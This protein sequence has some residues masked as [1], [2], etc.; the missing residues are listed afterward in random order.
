MLVIG[1]REREAGGAHISTLQLLVSGKLA[2]Q[3]V[4]ALGAE[5]TAVRI[6]IPRGPRGDPPETS[7]LWRPAAAS[8]SPVCV[9]Y[10]TAA[11]NGE[12]PAAALLCT[13][14]IGHSN[15]T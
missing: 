6:A 14:C 15:A 4:V 7:C 5:A 3:P 12:F 11:G 1:H 9:Y 13:V 10:Y 2:I 8:I